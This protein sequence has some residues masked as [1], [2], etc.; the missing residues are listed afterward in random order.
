[1]VALPLRMDRQVEN[2]ALQ[3]LES[4]QGFEHAV[5]VLAA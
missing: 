2:E 5:P 4:G 1:V 3:A